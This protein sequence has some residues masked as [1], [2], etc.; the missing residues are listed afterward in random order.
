MNRAAA[1]TREEMIPARQQ[2]VWGWA[3]VANFTL[4]GLGAGWY[5]M[6]VLAAGL[7][8]TPGVVA[9]SWAA[10]A[11]VLAGFIAVAGEAG[12][13]LRGLRVPARF[14]TS[15]MS[16]EALIG[17]M[18]V[19]LVAAELAWPLRLHRA[20]ALLAAALLALAQGFM[21]RRA[22]GV[23]A[24]DVPIMPL[25]FLLSA[26]LAGAGAVLLVEAGARRAVGAP[27]LAGVIALIVLSVVARA[28]YLAWSS[29]EA[30]VQAVALLRERR[31]ALVV[32]G[33]GHGL[34]VLLVTLALLVPVAAGPALGLAGALLVAGQAY[35]KAGLILDAGL[36]RP[37][38]LR[39]ARSKRRSP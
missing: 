3:A 6:A 8:R 23:T 9:A 12:R 37:V 31:A 5:T 1:V 22:R 17:G 20:L 4:G 16:R 21:V 34:P 14:W 7:D 36:L 27:L 28:R 25:L 24:W 29:Q 35:A 39:I 11:L 18:F 30:F 32:E 15:W 10:P 13:P 38:T 2:S 33:A 19:L 26:G